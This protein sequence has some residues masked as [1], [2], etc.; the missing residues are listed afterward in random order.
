MQ[1]QIS[2]L[3]VSTVA[4]QHIPVRRNIEVG[5]GQGYLMIHCESVALQAQAEK[6]A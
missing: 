2:A 4:P 6:A 1:E 5:H 3:T